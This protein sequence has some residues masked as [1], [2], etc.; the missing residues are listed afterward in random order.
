MHGDDVASAGTQIVSETARETVSTII[1][2]LIKIIESRME[3]RRRDREAEAER[4]ARYGDIEMHGEQHTLQELK[5]GGE[6]TG[7][8][9]TKEDYESFK[10][11]NKSTDM[12]YTAVPMKNSDYVDIYYLKS[13]EPVFKQNMEKIVED[14][15]KAPDAEF[16]MTILDKEKAEAFQ[17]YC[18][19]KNVPVNMLEAETGQ[20]KVIY[21]AE[22]ELA[23]KK[24]FEH[25]EGT[26]QSLKDFS[27]EVKNEKGKPQFIFSDKEQGKTLKM[28]LST[29]ERFENALINQLGYSTE[30]ANLA[31]QIALAKMSNEQKTFFLSGSKLENQVETYQKNIK[32]ESDDLLVEG[33]QFSKMKLK[34]DD[35]ERLVISDKDGNVAVI[36][37]DTSRA[38]LE[39]TIRNDLKITDTAQ[40]ESILYKSAKIGFTDKAQTKE[41]GNISITR[42]SQNKAELSF[43]E[44]SISVNLGDRNAAKQ[45]IMAEL[46]VSESKAEKMLDKAQ[47]QNLT[48][49]KLIN[50]KRFA[51]KSDA[52]IKNKK[53]TRG[54]RKQ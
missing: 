39:K 17:N 13:D 14:K 4:Q 18:A 6:I 37:P 23:V 40:A 36:H 34:C 11:L 21:D 43:G 5:K 48:K 26:Q 25:I 22:K 20:I 3:Q 1:N 15:L 46:G 53:P 19:E 9:L 31:S 41:Y 54:S 42:T 49:G 16:K 38:D 30:K 50:A 27:I 45:K 32:F 24:A 28:N 47:K 2:I 52:M 33:F 12:A 29:K 51:P 35:T 10:E 8:K 7:T 44:K